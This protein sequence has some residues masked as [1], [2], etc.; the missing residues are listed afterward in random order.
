MKRIVEARKLFNITKESNL[1][2]LKSIYRN[3]MKEWHPDKFVNDANRQEEAALRSKE[4]IEAYHFLISVSPET[5]L[6]NKEEYLVTIS[7]SGIDD[8]EYKGQTLKVTFQNGSVYE[9]FGVQKNTYNKLINSSTIT[10]F[11]RRH[12]FENHIYRKVSNQTVA[13]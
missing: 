8:F 7:D 12:I 9:Y 3:L 2:E 5:H 4:I 6:N 1:N 11:A 10:R 13:V